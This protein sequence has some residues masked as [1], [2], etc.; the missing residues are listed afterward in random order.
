MAGTVWL[1]FEGTLAYRPAMWAEACLE[2]LD[3]LVGGHGVSHGALD[4]A[5]ATGMP[6]HDPNSPHDHLDTVDRWWEAVTA[7]THA[8]V[9]ELGVE[10]SPEDLGAGVRRSIM[11][12]S[13]YRLFDD[14]L[15]ALELIGERGWR[16]GVVSNHIPALRGFAWARCTNWCSLVLG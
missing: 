4:A 8:V 14:T 15:D 3:D 6:W 1:D 5:L 10:C 2:V 7:R 9:E 13:R 16:A 12:P 11:D